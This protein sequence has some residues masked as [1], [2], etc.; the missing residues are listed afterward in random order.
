MGIYDREY[1]R[2]GGPRFLGSFVER[3]TVCKWLIG[4]NVACFIA[5]MLT[6]D[7]DTGR[8]WFTDL[9][10][11]DPGKVLHGQVWRL[12]T[13]AFLHSSASVLHILFNMLLLWWFGSDME[14]L[15]G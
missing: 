14:A 13:Y 7:P 8:S 3:G 2:G 1:Y 12:L 10:I 9:F 6:Q 15:Y 5:Q 11:L 4:I